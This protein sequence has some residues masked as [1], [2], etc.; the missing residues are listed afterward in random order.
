VNIELLGT[1][2][3]KPSYNMQTGCLQLRVLVDLKSTTVKL[4]QSEISAIIK[5]EYAFSL[6]IESVELDITEA[7]IVD[8]LGINL[9]LVLVKWATNNGAEVTLVVEVR[10]VFE[11][12]SAIG[13]QRL[14]KL[15]IRD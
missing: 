2:N 4:L 10:S 15:V 11:T 1:P 8:S 3:V 13:I 6:K 9:V 12:L 7:R 14:A 5:H